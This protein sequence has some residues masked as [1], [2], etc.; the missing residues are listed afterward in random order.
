MNLSTGGVQRG[1]IEHEP[2][3]GEIA[4]QIRIADLDA[5]EMQV[6]RDDIGGELERAERTGI[7]GGSEIGRQ[8]NFSGEAV[9]FGYERGKLRSVKTVAEK[10]RGRFHGRIDRQYARAVRGSTERGCLQV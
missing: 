1:F 9:G 5:F 3:A 10:V 8:R 2:H 7:V 4:R 6:I